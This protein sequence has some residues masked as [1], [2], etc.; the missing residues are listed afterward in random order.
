MKGTPSF[1]KMNKKTH[2]RC[3]RCGRNSFN[4]SGRYCAACGYGRSRRIRRY[5]WANK[6]VNGKRV[7]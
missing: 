3:R 1:G 6:K 4:I 2:M 5:R 7:R